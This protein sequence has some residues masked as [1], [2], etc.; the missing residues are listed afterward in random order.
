M[1]WLRPYTDD[2]IRHLGQSGVRSLLAVPISFVSEHIETLEEID[3]EYR[4]LAEESGITN[5]GRVPALNT[6][7]KFIQDLADLVVEQL[8]SAA[9]RPPA[10]EDLNLGPPSGAPHSGLTARV[11]CSC[12][13]MREPWSC[14]PGSREPTASAVPLHWS[15][16]QRGL[17]EH[18]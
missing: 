3:M 4:E 10:F 2:A 11:A 6:H 5:W 1:E 16:Q 8:P 14:K 12:A 9:P 7:P 18:L 13:G 17:Q 15:T